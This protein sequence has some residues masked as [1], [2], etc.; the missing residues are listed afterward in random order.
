MTARRHFTE[1]S[2]I[3]PLII[4]IF[5]HGAT[6]PLFY[7]SKFSDLGAS[8]LTDS[9]LGHSPKTERAGLRR[10]AEKL[11]AETAETV[12]ALPGSR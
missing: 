5:P 9:G 12:T 6:P 2:G 10:P 1:H 3:A 7:D 11:T 8:D 4:L